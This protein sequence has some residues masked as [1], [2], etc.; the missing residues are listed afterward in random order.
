M[1]VPWPIIGTSNHILMSIYVEG[2][3]HRV[4]QQVYSYIP[5]IST[6]P[7]SSNSNVHSPSSS[8]KASVVSLILAFSGSS[9]NTFTCLGSASTLDLICTYSCEPRQ[10]CILQ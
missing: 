9:P 8:P 5:S 1:A 4:Y 3:A 7:S 10:P 2:Q 6:S